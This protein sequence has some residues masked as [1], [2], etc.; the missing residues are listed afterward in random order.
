MSELTA[1]AIFTWG[2]FC[3]VVCCAMPFAMKRVV[4]A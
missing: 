3:G 2:L 1:L 4:N